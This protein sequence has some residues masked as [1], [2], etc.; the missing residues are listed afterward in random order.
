MLARIIA[1][2]RSYWRGLRKPEQSRELGREARRLAWMTGLSLDTKLAWRMLGKSPT[3]TVIGVLG[4][5]LGTTVG[6][7]FFVIASTIFFPKLPLN[8]SDRLVALENW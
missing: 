3:L 5:A 6:L 8:E 1:P 4:I 7:A 2:I